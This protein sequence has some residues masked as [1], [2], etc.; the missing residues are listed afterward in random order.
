MTI[1]SSE[2]AVREGGALAVQAGQTE[3]SAQQLAVLHS[4]GIKTD[5]TDAELTAFLHECQQR[6]L[7]PFSKQIYL[8]GR[9]DRREGR[10]VYRSQTGIDGF[11]V[12][13]HRAAAEAGQPIS[14][15]DT[16]WCGL[17][18]EWRDVWM[19]D[20]PPRAAKVVVTRDGQRFPA[21]ATLAE[22]AATYP[23]GNPLPMW[24][25][26]PATMLA[27]CAEAQSL[28]KAFP[29]DL[30]GIYT[31]EEMAQADNATREVPEPQERRAERAPRTGPADDEWTRP[32]PAEQS[33]PATV[34]AED[35]EVVDEEA[36]P[37]ANVRQIEHILS[38]L[39]SVRGITDVDA[40]QAAIEEMVGHP[41]RNPTELTFGEAVR[42]I[43][44][45]VAEHEAKQAPPAV[46]T[47][48]NPGITDGQKKLIQAHFSSWSRE[49]RLTE[50]ARI[51]DNGPVLSV[52]DLSKVEASRVIEA[53]GR[54]ATMEPPVGAMA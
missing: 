51:L 3:W 5:V 31:A 11:R 20:D 1:L 18:G 47:P 43:A 2:V 10:E 45:L 44:A 39:A 30:S 46:G 38:G 40:K 4:V 17:D 9:M 36:A 29:D 25:R 54:S 33:A 42:V 50:I 15:E 35:I 12:I 24:K 41:V 32:A 26:M 53:I 27:K 8:I 6:R 16:L 19:F 22:Y 7:D 34:E 48:N 52:N 23:D 28:R 21:V 37:P 49:N 14:Y 13:A